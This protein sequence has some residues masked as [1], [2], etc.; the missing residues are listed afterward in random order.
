M[1]IVADSGST[2]CDWRLVVDEENIRGFS[3]IGFNPFFHDEDFIEQE[4]LKETQLSQIASEVT[5][6]Y[7][8]C[9]GGSNNSLRGIVER[10]LARIFVNAE[11]HIDHDL[12]AAA[13][14]TWEGT[15]S[16][17]GILGTGSNSCYYDGKNVREEVPALAYILG[18]EGSGSYYGKIILRK[19]LY[20][21]LPE[22]IHNSL[23]E[24]YGLTKDNIFENVY[25]KPHANVYLASIMKMVS[26][27][28]DDPFIVDMITEGM[29]RY[30][31]EHIC[32]F[33]EHKN[34]PVH[35][36]GSIGYYFENVLRSEA[37]K[38]GIAIGTISKKPINGLVQF[39]L[40]KV[41]VEG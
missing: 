24:Q 16:I 30:L 17:A 22:H 40:R 29:N 18:D 38:L 8:Y 12:N 14:S 2:K 7:F 10:G 32:C 39:H 26:L 23:E 13:F 36:V 9:A 41:S 28:K 15:P 19:Y 1:I 37:Q 27:Y 25:M 5:A 6:V 21:Q 3:T 33:P 31:R 11:M 4:I 34:V 35:I 20:N